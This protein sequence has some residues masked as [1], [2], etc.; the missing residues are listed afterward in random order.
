MDLFIVRH[1]ES[2]GQI[3]A[4]YNNHPDPALSALGERQAQAAAARLATLAVTQ[5]VSSPLL[6]AL[7]TAAS[8]AEAAHHPTIQVWPELVEGWTGPYQ[9]LQRHELL[10]RFPRADL[11]ASFVDDAGWLHPGDYTYEEYCARADGVLRR[12]EA[13]FAHVDRVVVVTHGGLANALLNAILQIPPATPQWFEL[14]NASLTQVHLVPDPQQERFG[15][16]YVLYPPVR[17]EVQ[18]VNDTAHLRF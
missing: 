4:A 8:I 17:A 16:G 6:R 7:G 5:I 2:L 1:G 15:G 3:E 11:P 10:R 18:S 14:Q 9:G 12:I 13:T